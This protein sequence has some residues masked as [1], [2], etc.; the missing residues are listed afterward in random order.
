MLD[1]FKC[2]NFPRRTR[3][4]LGQ[5]VLRRFSTIKHE[6]CEIYFDAAEFPFQAAVSNLEDMIWILTKDVKEALPHHFNDW[7]D[8]NFH[9]LDSEDFSAMNISQ[10]ESHKTLYTLIPPK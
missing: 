7:E 3:V 4:L 5:L 1:Q 2:I 8:D 9:F 10:I 6:D